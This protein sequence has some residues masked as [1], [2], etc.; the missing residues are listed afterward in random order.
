[1][2]KIESMTRYFLENFDYMIKN[3]LEELS[4]KNKNT[5]I[6]DAD[7]STEWSNKSN[8]QKLGYWIN[9]SDGKFKDTQT[10][11]KQIPLQ[12]ILFPKHF[13]S[14]STIIRFYWNKNDIRE[15]Q[16]KE[17]CPFISIS[18]VFFIDQIVYPQKSQ[19][20]RNWEIRDLV[21]SKYKVNTEN[22]NQNIK[23][24]FK[25]ELASNVYIKDLENIIIGKFEEESGKWNMNNIEMPDFLKE[26]KIIT[27]YSNELANFSILLER[28]IFFPY[29]SWYLRCINEKTAILDLESNYIS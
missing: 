23:I 7:F 29:K 5:G 17:Y 21:G 13:V 27:F 19:S 15:N 25:I 2:S 26:K 12:I 24:Q 4:K 1:M 3:I 6:E 9:N 16:K 22:T 8:T 20:A 10:K 28:K 18:G 14:S 11:F